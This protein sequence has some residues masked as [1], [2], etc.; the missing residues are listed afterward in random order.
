MD[1]KITMRIFLLVQAAA[2]CLI[3]ASCSLPRIVIFED[4]LS[5]QEH[6][7]LGV[8]YENKG[9]LDPAIKEYETAAKNLPL[10]YLYLGNAYMRKA[11]YEKAERSYQK[12]ID[13]GDGIAEAYNNL[14]W[15]Y[16]TQKRNMDEAEELAAKAVELRPT[17][18]NFADTLK[19]IRSLKSKN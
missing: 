5:P 4:P 18:P 15:L 12:A 10:G 8:A 14:A 7:N 3:L 11:D 6:I 16:Y 2:L 19:K 9:E 1:K 13:K 17:D